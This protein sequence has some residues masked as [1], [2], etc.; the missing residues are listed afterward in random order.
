MARPDDLP[1]L[2]DQG[3]DAACWADRVCFACGRLDER[4]AAARDGRCPSCG[5]SDAD[6]GDH[7]P[8]AR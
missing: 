4:P 2:D 8:P 6:D 1:A 5:A 7:P 3:G